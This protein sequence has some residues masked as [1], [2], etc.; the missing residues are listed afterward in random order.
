[1]VRLIPN[2]PQIL[3][4]D[5]GAIANHV[6]LRCDAC[7]RSLPPQP[8]AADRAYVQWRR[9]QN[10]PEPTHD[11]C[12]GMDVPIGPWGAEEV[13][14]WTGTAHYQPWKDVAAFFR[15]PPTRDNHACGR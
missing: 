15:E 10:R 4:L 14:F 1:M 13:A 3:C 8:T 9:S 7:R 11:I 2:G 5:C 6:T 12:T